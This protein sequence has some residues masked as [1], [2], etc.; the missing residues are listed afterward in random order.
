MNAKGAT[1]MRDNLNTPCV[2]WEG[3]RTSQGYGRAYLNG[4]SHVAHR[5]AYCEANGLSLDDIK[6]FVVRH[7]CDN[8]PCVNLEHLELGTQSE[9][10]Q[11]K[12]RRGRGFSKLTEEQVADMRRKYAAGGTTHKELAEEYGV[13]GATICRILKGDLWTHLEVP[14]YQSRG[15]KGVHNAKA[16]LTEDQVR[17]IRARCASGNETQKSIAKEFGL[18]PRT[19]CKIHRREKWG[20]LS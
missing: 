8:P 3:A 6:G 14:H 1:S 18:H 9:N 13:W 5:L 2:E 10:M 11:D 20:H 16:K 19:V 7:K 15:R 4:K 12:A 17:D